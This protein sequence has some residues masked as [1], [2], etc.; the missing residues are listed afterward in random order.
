MSK[1]STCLWFDSNGEEAVKFYSS[2]FK[3]TKVLKIAK[4]G[5]NMPGTEGQVMTIS[6]RML[7]QNFLALN[8]GPSFKFTEAISLVVICKTQKEIDS[9]WKK[10]SADGGQ[11]GQCGWLKDKFGL[12]WQ[13]APD[14]GKYLGNKS[15]GQLQ[16]VMDVVMKSTKLDIK[17]IETAFKSA[18]PKKKKKK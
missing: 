10:L 3:G 11:T 9:Y 5:K 17:Q 1:L 12:S 7:G 18:A 13:V 14:M 16:A 4:F 15:S 2:V 6:F 8:G